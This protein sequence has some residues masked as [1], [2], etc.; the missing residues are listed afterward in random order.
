[1]RY[2]IAFRHNE[3]TTPPE[4]IEQMTKSCRPFDNIIS[5]SAVEMAS[6]NRSSFLIFF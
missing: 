2:N 4:I 6:V 5:A 1:M 3:F